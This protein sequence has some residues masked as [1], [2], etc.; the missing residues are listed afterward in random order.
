MSLGSYSFTSQKCKSNQH[1]S[2]EAAWEGL[3]IGLNCNCRCHS[4]KSYDIS[5]V[6]TSGNN[7]EKLLDGSEK[8]PD[9]IADWRIS[10]FYTTTKDKEGR[11]PENVTIIEN[12]PQF[13]DHNN[14][15]LSIAIHN[16]VT[17]YLTFSYERCIGQDKNLPDDLILNV[18]AHPISQYILLG[19][20]FQL[21]S[22]DNQTL[23]NRDPEN[24]LLPRLHGCE[25]Q[26]IFVNGKVLLLF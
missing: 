26:N 3:G 5:E 6:K 11:N 10:E 14:I 22:K 1:E 20:Q 16:L 2:C 24:G 12:K 7:H 4:K 23:M 18:F 21:L 15:I 8:A 25:N 17:E 9:S 13:Q 19:A